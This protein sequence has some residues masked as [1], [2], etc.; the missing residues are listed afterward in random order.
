MILERIRN[1]ALLVPFG[2]QSGTLSHRDRGDHPGLPA[3]RPKK[4]ELFEGG[5]RASKPETPFPLSS[6]I[7]SPHMSNPQSMPENPETSWSELYTA[8]KTP[9]S[10]HRL[11]KKAKKKLTRALM[12]DLRYR[13][14]RMLYRPMQRRSMPEQ[15]EVSLHQ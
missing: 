1:L 3:L 4:Q 13:H 10:K 6:P 5:V 15:S 9:Y 11:E 2:T 7:V 12:R 8:Y 14:S